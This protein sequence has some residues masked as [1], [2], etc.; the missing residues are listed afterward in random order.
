VVVAAIVRRAA[1]ASIRTL[2]RGLGSVA[3]AK[4]NIRIDLFN[5]SI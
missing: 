3:F 5:E 1:I 4:Y 2:P